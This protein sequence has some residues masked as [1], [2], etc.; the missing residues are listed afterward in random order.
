MDYIIEQNIFLNNSL[1]PL[2]VMNSIHKIYFDYIKSLYIY[3]MRIRNDIIKNDH[4]MA[5]LSLKRVS[6]IS[7]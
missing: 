6:F 3:P 1:F 7:N 5:N 2:Q 4:L